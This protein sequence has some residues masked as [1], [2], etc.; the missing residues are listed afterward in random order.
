MI[1]K[2]IQKVLIRNN[3]LPNKKVYAGGIIQMRKTI[4]KKK[5]VVRDWPFLVQG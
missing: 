2:T 1:C 3:N 4:E 5:L